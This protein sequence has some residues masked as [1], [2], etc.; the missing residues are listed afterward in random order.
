MKNFIIGFVI[1]VVVGIS[2]TLWIQLMQEAAA[3]YEQSEK[4]NIVWRQNHFILNPENLYNELKAQ[5]I[6]YPEIVMA[7]AILETGH[8]KSNACVNRNNLFGLRCGDG[9][10][11]YFN[12]WT[13]CVEAYKCYIQ[14]WKEIPKDYFSYLDSLGYAEDSLYIPKLKQI[15]KQ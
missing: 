15:I 10:Y 2:C 4:V 13:D 12:H 14:D 9:T 6:E 7:Q 8:F 3:K 11:M 5:G 1:G